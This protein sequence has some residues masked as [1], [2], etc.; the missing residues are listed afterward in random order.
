MKR[1]K[2][3]TLVEL[4][5]VITII[6][7]LAAIL[8]PA[9]FS[10]LEA[11]NRASCQNNL[12]QIGKAFR[13]YAAGHEQRWPDVFDSDAASWDNV[14][15]TRTD[16][17]DP[18]ADAGVPPAEKAEDNKG[19]IESNTANFWVLVAA[20]Y[21]TPSSFVCRS[22]SSMTYKDESV[23]DFSKVRDFRGKNF[24]S[25]SLQNLYGGYT[26]T[27]TVSSKTATLAV[28][29]DANPQR[30]D[31]AMESGVSTKKLAESPK[32]EVTEWR[33]TDITGLWELNSPNHKFKGQNVL[34]LDGHVEFQDNPYCGPLH[35]NIWVKRS[36]SAGST[37]DIDT[38]DVTTLQAFDDDSSYDGTSA[39]DVGSDDSFLVP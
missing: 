1:H 35:D 25:Y 15:G 7:M 31:F 33:Q 6:G 13:T 2:G 14:G 38:K 30:A 12:S 19:L 37:D 36:S 23:S 4:L 3:F 34:Y 29:A 28:A 5:V 9:A 27:E 18:T 24:C 16:Q 20:E 21:V 22:A 10:A 17:F 11:A 39:L 26:L 32:F 8:M